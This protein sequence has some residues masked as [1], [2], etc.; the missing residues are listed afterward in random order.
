MPASEIF[1]LCSM[2]LNM[3]VVLFQRYDFLI[4]GQRQYMEKPKRTGGAVVGRG[5]PGRTRSPSFPW[6]Y[7]ILT[8]TR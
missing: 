6:N 8:V 5:R 7:T 1:I 2:S 4:S 3:I